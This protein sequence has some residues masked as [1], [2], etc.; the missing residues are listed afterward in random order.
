MHAGKDVTAI[1]VDA[2]VDASAQKSELTGFARMLC[3]Y[4]SQSVTLAALALALLYLTVLSFGNVMI[5]WYV[6]GIASIQCAT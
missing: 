3:V 1:T 5:A 2:D 6:P 4:T